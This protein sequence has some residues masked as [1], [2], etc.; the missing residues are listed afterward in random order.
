MWE[1]PGLEGRGAVAARQLRRGRAFRGIA[2]RSCRG[3]QV[4]CEYQRQQRGGPP[5]DTD[6]V[7]DMD[8]RQQRSNY[9]YGPPPSSSRPPPGGPPAPPGGG[10]NNGPGGGMSNFTKAL[11][12]GAFIMGMGT[13]VWFNSE[14]NFQPNNVAS[15]EILDRQTPSSQIC[16][17]N[18]Y[19]SMV[20]DQRLFVSFNPFNVYVAQTEVKPG[21][22]LRRSNI[23]VLES[24]KLVMSSE[25]NNCKRSMNTFA[26]VGDLG[27]SPEVSCVYHS[28]DAENQYLKNPK[29]A[30]M[31]DGYQ[32]RPDLEP[33]PIGNGNASPKS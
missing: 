12:A 11:I 6:Y 28:E 24:R 13:G 10:D 22:V 1:P 3:S 25:V 20:F 19:S 4:R 26:F 7:D 14:V 15:T 2:S 23:S 18:G 29:Q 17:A 27:K 33:Q 9:D 30:I 21:C 16:V 32:V 5:R 31:G 8:F